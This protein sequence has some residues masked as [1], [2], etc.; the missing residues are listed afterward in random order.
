MKWIIQNATG[1]RAFLLRQLPLPEWRLRALLEKGC[2]SADGRT[3]RK[4]MPLT[5][6]T[7]VEVRLPKAFLP[8][9]PVLFE[10]RS[11]LVVEKPRGIE[12]C[13]SETG[14]LTLDEVLRLMGYED[15]LPCHRL[16]THTGGVMLF[17]R[18]EAAEAASRELFE[19]HELKKQYLAVCTGT[20]G[21]PSGDVR[22]FLVRR[23]GKSRITDRPQ[24]G[25]LPIETAYRILAQKEGLGLAEVGL[26]T[27][28]THQIRAHFASWGCPL[29]GDD[30]YGDRDANRAWKVRY[31]C[32]W[33]VSLT[34]P[35]G[36]SGP[37]AELSGRTFTSRPQFPARITELFGLEED[38]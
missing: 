33:A 23:D 27:G 21:R 1:L 25:A 35:D 2:V 3:V 6:G 28:R 16:D 22:A 32:L 14:A 38:V 30:L 13:D 34:F 8:K 10:G 20:P 37:L 17:A 7:R 19:S 5:P 36:L 24:P 9:V 29:L 4:D 18:G 26:V 12:V 31:P 15:A 11:F